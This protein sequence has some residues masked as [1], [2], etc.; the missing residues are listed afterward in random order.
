MG[1]FFWKY[2]REEEIRNVWHSVFETFK[3]GKAIEKHIVLA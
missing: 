2:G 1:R 3:R